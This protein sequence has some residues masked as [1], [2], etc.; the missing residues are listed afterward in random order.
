MFTDICLRDYT[1]YSLVILHLGNIFMH[2]YR[3]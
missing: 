1:I 2:I 3:V